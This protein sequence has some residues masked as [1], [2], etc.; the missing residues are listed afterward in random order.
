MSHECNLLPACFVRNGKNR[1]ARNQRL[2]LDEIR[3]A[4][5][6]IIHC[7]AAIFRGL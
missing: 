5:F 7:A 4:L 3:A 2:Q 6:Q 1:I